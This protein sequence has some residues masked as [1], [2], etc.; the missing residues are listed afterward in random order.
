MHNDASPLSNGTHIHS[1]KSLF[2]IAFVANLLEWY[3]FSIY[4]LLAGTMGLLFFKTSHP[5]MAALSAFTV[6][7]ISYLARPLGSLCFGYIGDRIGR[8]DALKL[9]LLLMAVPTVLIGLLPNF[10]QVG[11]FATGL[12]ILLRLIQGFAVGGEMPSSA[13]YVFEASDPH[14]R[15]LLTSIVWASA[16]VGFLLAAFVAFLL[17]QYFDQETILAWAWRIPFLLGIPITLFIITMRKS[18]EEPRWASAIIMQPF[19]SILRSLLPKDKKALLKSILLTAF[20]TSCVYVFSI[21]MPFYLEHFLKIES[22]LSFFTNT[23]ATIALCITPIVSASAA[24]YFGYHRLIN[25]LFF[26]TLL[27]VYP[28]FKGL[29]QGN[30]STIVLLSIQIAFNFLAG[31]IGGN[32]IEAVGRLFQQSERARGMNIAF[33]C[34]TALVGGMTPLLCTWFT[35]QTGFLTFPAF[36]ILFWGVLALP[37]VLSLKS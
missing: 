25:I 35:Y 20:T 13:C 17:F 31:A 1:L 2:N 19:S 12:L 29:I 30:S 16:H 28:L 5:I 24:Y 6:F 22:S 4:G 27:L 33:T 11:F 23:L 9:S 18:I 37:I 7:A 34:S 14:H 8:S 21:W 32:V 10:A 26:A 15:L 3:E 36:Y